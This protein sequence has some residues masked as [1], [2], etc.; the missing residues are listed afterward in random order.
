MQNAINLKNSTLRT[1]WF[2][3]KGVLMITVVVLVCSF[4]FKQGRESAFS[5]IQREHLAGLGFNV[6]GYI[7]FDDG[8]F[9]VEKNNTRSFEQF[10]KR[11]GFDSI[12]K[13]IAY[14]QNVE[15]L[16][17]EWHSSLGWQKMINKS[18]ATFP[19]KTNPGSTGFQVLYHENL[20]DK[21]RVYNYGFAHDSSDSYQIVIAEKDQPFIGIE[22]GKA[23]V[24]TTTD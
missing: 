23:V 4:F 3:L 17:I 18:L 10:M 8:R 12:S 2:L 1:P 22:G 13:R 11:E 19:V 6:L 9:Y 5:E 21:Y 20:Q 24:N 16:K 15:T 7:S 14:I